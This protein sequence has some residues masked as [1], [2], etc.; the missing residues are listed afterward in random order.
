[1]TAFAEFNQK[2]ASQRFSSFKQLQNNLKEFSDT[3]GYRFVNSKFSYF[4]QG[5]Q[6]RERFIYKYLDLKCA[7]AKKRNC[8][9][10][11]NVRCRHSIMYIRTWSMEHNHPPD[12]PDTS[13]LVDCTESFKHIFPVRFFD[14]L[15]D[16]EA[17]IHELERLGQFYIDVVLTPDLEFI[18][19]SADFTI[20]SSVT[21]TRFTKYSTRMLPESNEYRQR[22]VYE[23]VNYA[24]IHAGKTKTR[25][26]AFVGVRS[27]KIGCQAR[28]R[29]CIAKDKLKVMLYSMKH[30]HIVSNDFQ[31]PGATQSSLP[32]SNEDFVVEDVEDADVDY[33][34]QLPNLDTNVFRGDDLPSIPI[35]FKKTRSSRQISVPI[36]RCKRPSSYA[37]YYTSANNERE[38]GICQSSAENQDGSLYSSRSDPRRPKNPRLASN[39]FSNRRSGYQGKFYGAN[40]K[41][42]TM[43]MTMRGG[44]LES[45]DS[46][47]EA[48]P[49]KC[50]ERGTPAHLYRSES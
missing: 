11:C 1:M 23:R 46:S 44:E 25:S 39:A 19:Q 24:C 10:C 12:P 40:I 45:T 20:R 8:P 28:I 50:E 2:I 18:V 36:R 29:A 22:L 26:S 17:K 38:S 47:E 5:T 42:N 16:L 14:S 48:V 34:L 43:K 31:G 13:T 35:V 7:Y 27:Q 33:E 37:D 15:Q 6:N 21:G 9:A 41:E 3:F 30:N 49:V 32:P 4:P